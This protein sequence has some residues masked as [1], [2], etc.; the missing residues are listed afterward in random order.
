MSE[1][2][3][4]TPLATIEAFEAAAFRTAHVARKLLA[5][6]PDLSVNEIRPRAATSSYMR[7]DDM[8]ALEIST[9]TV[10]DVR[11]WAEALGA[12]V[13]ITVHADIPGLQTRPFAIHRCTARIGGVEV[14]AIDSRE[15]TEEEVAAWRA[16][17]ER[18]AAERESGGAP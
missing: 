2:I 3:K 13:E 6:H 17:Q 18:A 5:D 7:D 1:R 9:D 12:E 10:D 8:G 16:E 11:A 14:K 15:L 4:R